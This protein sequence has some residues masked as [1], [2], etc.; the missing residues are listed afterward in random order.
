MFII[1]PLSLQP[2][3]FMDSLLLHPIQAR[4]RAFLRSRNNIVESV[5]V[6]CFLLH[7][8]VINSFKIQLHATKKL[9]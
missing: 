7:V 2:N 3:I 5:R 6:V 8:H 9:I 1:I 4:W